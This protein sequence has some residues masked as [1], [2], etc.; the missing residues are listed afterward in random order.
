MGIVWG[1][2]AITI[3]ATYFFCEFFPQKCDSFVSWLRK[4]F[5][6]S[7]KGKSS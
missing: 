4:K 3:S 1:I 5:N 2:L 7:K 6:K